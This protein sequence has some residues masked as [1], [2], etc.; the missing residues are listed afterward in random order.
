MKWPRQKIIVNLPTSD[1]VWLELLEQQHLQ[2]KTNIEANFHQFSEL[3]EKFHALLNA[4]ANNRFMNDFQNT[5][6]LIFHYH[7][8]WNKVDE[9]E[10]NA[11]A[12]DEH[13]KYIQA[14]RSRDWGQAKIAVSTHLASARQTLLSS[15][16]HQIVLLL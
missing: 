16:T 13:L 8:Q 7:F 4:K 6:S 2:L 11:K 15:T 9:K 12:I 14:L 3:D 5:I 1:P 10:R